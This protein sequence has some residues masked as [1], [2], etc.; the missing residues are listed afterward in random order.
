M[1]W[2]YGWSTRKELADHLIS[3]NGVHTVA[4]CF[5]GNNLWAVQE[6]TYPARTYDDKPH[7]KAGE[8]V[9]FI[10]LY[11]LRGSNG[12]R[13]GW[14]Y[15]DMDESAGPY[16]YNCPLSYLDMV[17]EPDAEFAKCWRIKVREYHAKATRQLTRGQQ[18]KLY[19]QDY[20]VVEGPRPDGSYA[21]RMVGY[22]GH[23]KMPKRMIKHV[24]VLA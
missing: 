2:L 21:I 24:E 22:G 18:I 17:P 12:S 15:K 5:K 4:H 3:G 23:F 8:T 13:D 19:G 1:G 11:L 6:Y 9:R 10:A 14:G 20:E 7:P 16:Y